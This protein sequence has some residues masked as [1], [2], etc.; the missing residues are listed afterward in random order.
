QPPTG[1]G[2][3]QGACVYAAMIAKAN[4]RSGDTFDRTGI[5]FVTRLINEADKLAETINGFA[6]FTCAIARHSDNRVPV[7]EMTQH[8]IL[9]ITHQAYA[10]A[11]EDAVLR[12]GEDRLED[13]LNWNAGP[14]FLTII[15]ESLANL[16]ASYRATEEDF[17]LVSSFFDRDTVREFQPLLDHFKKLA[18]ALGKTEALLD[19]FPVSNS[20]T[21]RLWAGPNNN[22][23]WYVHRLTLPALR[24]KMSRLR[25]DRILTRSDDAS[26]NMSVASRVDRTLRAY[27]AF[28]LGAAYRSGTAGVFT[29][30]ASRLLLPDE[31]HG[32]VILDATAEQEP[33]WELLGNRVRIADRVEGVRNYRDVRLHVSR[34]NAVG[35]SGMT[36]RAEG[37]LTR[38][39]DNL[40][41]TLKGRRIFLCLHKQLEPLATSFEPP[42]QEYS[43]DH[44][45]NVDGRNDWQEF[46]A[47]ILFG[48]PYRPDTWAIDMMQAV[49]QVAT[50]GEILS[51]GARKKRREIKQTLQNRQIA[52]SLIQAI[53]RIRCRRVVDGD[54]TCA[55]ADVYIVLP[56]NKLGN[57]VLSRI[58]SEMPGIQVTPWDFDLDGESRLVRRAHYVEPVISY[59][60]QQ[61]AGDV[62][63]KT[64]CEELSLSKNAKK[65]MQRDLKDQDNPFTTHLAR[66]G[67]TYHSVGRGRGARSFLAK[68]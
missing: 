33:L 59:M 34:A 56:P 66:M 46:D 7:E 36:Q 35:K 26:L 1:T 62:D 32:P 30:H 15:D 31:L 8:D 27:E 47:A 12:H 23:D 57:D 68:R 40:G 55:E 60:K 44:W 4:R 17:R 37:R 20:E 51:I 2:K 58:R 14:R 19:E 13:F 6:G 9:I 16:V 42:F 54:G 52:A 64:L 67:I 38:L 49:R 21:N 48:L 28:N 25:Y 53:N 29:V 43:V 61:A 41:D 24:R 5:L 45:G 11:L 63:L 50:A 65:D 18:S 10:N 3:T 22:I 39:L